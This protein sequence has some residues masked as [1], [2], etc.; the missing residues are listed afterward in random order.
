MHPPRRTRGVLLA[1]LSLLLLGLGLNVASAASTPAPGWAVSQFATGFPDGGSIGPIG[2]TFDTAGNLLA[3]NW[4]GDHNLY[5]F[6]PAGGAADAT[7]RVGSTPAFG[8]TTGKDGHIYASTLG[9]VV[10]IDPT[11]GASSRTLAAAPSEGIATD[12]KSGDLFIAASGCVIER[13]SNYTSAAVTPTVSTYASGVCADGLAFGPDGTLYA[14]SAPNIKRISGT[15]ISPTTV[16]TLATV[17]GGIDGIAV[18]ADNS[19]LVVNRNDGTITKVDLSSATQTNIVTGGSRGDFVTVGPDGCLYATQSTSVEKVTASDGSCPFV[20]VIPPPTVTLSFPPTPA[21]GWFSTAPVTGSATAT[22]SAG[23]TIASITCTDSLGHLTVGAL[24]TSGSDGT[25]S[26]S[27]SGDGTHTITCTATDA[28]GRK[29]VSAPATVKID[30]TAPTCKAAAT[31][32]S[33]WP[34][35]HKLVD[36]AVTVTP[37]DA[38]GGSGIA[39]PAFTLVSVTSNEPDNGLGD[40]DTANDIQGWSVG[41]PDTSGQ[42]RA[43]RSGTGNGRVYT[44]TYQV[45]DVAGNTATCTATVTVAHDQGN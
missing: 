22:A 24:S 7:T 16:T 40:G 38:T 34:P 37:S 28:G 14:A 39:T 41:T 26:L 30:T 36:V 32:S 44:L 12:P 1:A 4:G 20:P 15:A 31:P 29:G 17:P 35:N 45:K 27:V 2:V 19:F 21:S 8:L 3:A 18:A 9:N 33:V 42:L 23:G 25:V 11:S 13:I 10:E 5:K 6:G 43:E